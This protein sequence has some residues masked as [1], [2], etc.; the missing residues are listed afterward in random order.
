MTFRGLVQLTMVMVVRRCR[1]QEC[2]LY[3]LPYQAEE[4]GAWALLSSLGTKRYA[5]PVILFLFR[6]GPLECMLQDHLWQVRSTE[7]DH[8]E[9]HTGSSYLMALLISCGEDKPVKVFT[10]WQVS[11]SDFVHQSVASESTLCGLEGRM[12][13][14]SIHGFPSVF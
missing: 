3:H 4:E 11:P 5:S 14:Y 9:P 8:H 6:N 13:S 2:V 12:T 1:N 10:D 7:N